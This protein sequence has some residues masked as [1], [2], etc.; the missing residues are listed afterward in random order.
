MTTTFDHSVQFSAF[1]P[2]RHLR[3]WCEEN[4]EGGYHLEM[5]HILDHHNDVK[6]LIYTASFESMYDETMFKLVWLWQ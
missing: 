1:C 2:I 4:C 3:K 6:D 5:E